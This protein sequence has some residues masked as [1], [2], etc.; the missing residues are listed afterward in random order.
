VEHK[1]PVEEA[2]TDLIVLTDMGFDEAC[3]GGTY[4]YKK[5]APWLTHVQMIQSSFLKEGYTPPRIVLWNLRAAYKDF[6]AKAEEEGVVVLSGWSPSQLKVL[7]ASG[8]QVKTP[9]EGLREILDN[10]RYD[11]VR[12]AWSSIA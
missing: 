5:T 6:H 4:H 3:G 12:E 8:V 9:Y 1:V 11:K 10:A 2:P 7:S